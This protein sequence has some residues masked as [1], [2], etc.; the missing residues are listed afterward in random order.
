[1][2]GFGGTV[3]LP[4]K[5]GLGAASEWIY[6]GNVYS[7]QQAKEVGLV[8]AIFPPDELLGEVTKIAKVIESRSGVAVRASKGSMVTGLD[9]DSAGASTHEQVTFGSLF[10]TEDMREGTQA[11][12]QKRPPVFTN[13]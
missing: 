8:H 3:R 9:K 13:K 1:M 5:I 12:L 2:P 11:F 10:N 6:T 4:R 7:A